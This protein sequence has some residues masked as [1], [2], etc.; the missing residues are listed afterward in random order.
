MRRW[1]CQRPPE[2]AYPFALVVRFLLAEQLGV[3]VSANGMS[4]VDSWAREVITPW[5][6]ISREIC[7]R[8]SAFVADLRGCAARSKRCTE[9]AAAVVAQ[10]IRITTVIISNFI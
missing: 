2:P 9:L 6:F 8:G 3:E 5:S 7:S 4:V 10:R 1:A